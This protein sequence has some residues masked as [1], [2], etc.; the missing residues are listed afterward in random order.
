MSFNGIY[1]LHFRAFLAFNPLCL[2]IIAFIRCR[3]SRVTM[4]DLTV[5]GVPCK[6][7]ANNGVL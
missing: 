1:Q 2:R 6:L 5:S 3:A 4:R 7:N